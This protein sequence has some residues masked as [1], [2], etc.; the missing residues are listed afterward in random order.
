MAGRPVYSVC[1]LKITNI[2]GATVYNP[3]AGTIGVVRDMTFW[4]PGS[5]AQHFSTALLV[6]LD[7]TGEVVWDL[8]GCNMRPGVYHWQGRQVFTE[9]MIVTGWVDPYQFRA[10]GYLL[11]TP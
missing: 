10:S 5:V 11:T 8:A 7:D 9:A 1:F 2:S 4:V 6:Q 3:P